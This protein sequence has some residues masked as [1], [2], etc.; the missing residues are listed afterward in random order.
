[1]TPTRRKP[2]RRRGRAVPD[3][4][5]AVSEVGRAARHLLAARVS[6][7]GPTPAIGALA[8]HIPADPVG[9]SGANTVIARQ[10]DCA[11]N[12]SATATPAFTFTLDNVP[13]AVT[14]TPVVTAIAENTATATHIKIADIAIT[15]ITGTTGKN[16][17]L[18]GTGSDKISG[19][20]GKDTMTGGQGGD[21]FVF[22]S[23]KDT[24]KTA[25]KRD[26]IT[27]FKHGQDKIDLHLIDANT[28]KKGDQAFKFI[29]L[30]AFSHNPAE[31]QFSKHDAKGTANDFTLV[32]GDTNGDGKAD[33]QIELKGLINL[34]KSDFIL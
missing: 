7:F 20:L 30:K 11:G 29:A 21:I 22:G 9:V 12:R 24:G 28:L 33:F 5:E 32:E 26:V 31:L 13:T 17:L 23:A 10:V 18:G 19:G 8:P 27:D 14:L 25:A 4:A 1:V 6:A 16:A 3:Q 15:L 34:T 2:R